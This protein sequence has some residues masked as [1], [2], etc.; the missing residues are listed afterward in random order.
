MSGKELHKEPANGTINIT[1]GNREFGRVIMSVTNDDLN[2]RQRR[3]VDFF[4]PFRLLKLG[5]SV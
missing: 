5:E 4:V 2:R 1:P 3:K